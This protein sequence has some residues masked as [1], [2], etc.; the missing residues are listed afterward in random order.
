[1]FEWSMARAV[2]RVCGYEKTYVT[3][4]LDCVHKIF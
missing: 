3:M 2:V 4:R 1:M